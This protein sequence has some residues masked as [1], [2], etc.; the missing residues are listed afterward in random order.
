MIEVTER[1]KQ[2]LEKMR[3]ANNVKPEQFLRLVA[4][5]KDSLGVGIDIEQP[6]DYQV[7]HE[8]STVLLVEEKLA[9]ILEGITLDVEITEEGPN[10]FI[11]STEDKDKPAE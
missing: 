11:K 7:E 10:L 6:G 4:L 9:T 1:A 8:G 3:T 5:D 2:E